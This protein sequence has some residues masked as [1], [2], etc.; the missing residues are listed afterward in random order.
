[1]EYGWDIVGIAM[2]YQWHIIGMLMD[3][4]VILMDI[5]GIL[6]DTYRVSMGHLMGYMTHNQQYIYIN[7][8]SQEYEMDIANQLDMIWGFV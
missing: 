5:H 2:G 4:S 7:R 8:M 3:I 6:I 1:M